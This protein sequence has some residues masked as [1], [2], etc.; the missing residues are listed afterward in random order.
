MEGLSRQKHALKRFCN[1]N[2]SPRLL[3]KL[4]FYISSTM[5]KSNLKKLF[6]VYKLS[7]LYKDNLLLLII[8]NNTSWTYTCIYVYTHTH[9]VIISS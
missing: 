9:I 1:N 2:F 4:I 8:N 3:V 6:A 5:C 7:R